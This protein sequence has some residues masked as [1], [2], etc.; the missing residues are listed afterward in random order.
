MVDYVGRY[1]KMLNGIN[2]YDKTLGNSGGAFEVSK[3][4]EGIK[5]DSNNWC[6]D[7]LLPSCNL[8]VLNEV[9]RCAFL[10]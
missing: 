8:N 1:I 7:W 3:I 10:C 9:S 5:L 4:R 2:N 6:C